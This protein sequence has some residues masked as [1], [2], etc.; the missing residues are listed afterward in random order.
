MTEPTGRRFLSRLRSGI[1]WIDPWA[2][3]IVVVLVVG[4]VSFWRVTTADARRATD[5]LADGLEYFELE[6]QRFQPTDREGRGPRRCP[7]YEARG[8]VSFDDPID[9]S[10]VEPALARMEHDGWLVD[11]WFRPGDES[12]DRG[13]ITASRGDDMITVSL[14]G[15]RTSIST[16]TGQCD[17]AYTGD[18]GPSYYRADVIPPP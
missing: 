6:R 7:N 5:L 18:P 9:V 14:S 10:S 17:W 12:S 3:V 4:N 15:R 11:R 2:F 16:E 13:I 8:L 1:L